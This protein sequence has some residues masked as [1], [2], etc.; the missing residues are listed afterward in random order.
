[1]VP[2]RTLVLGNEKSH[3]VTRHAPHYLFVAEF[4]ADLLDHPIFHA[5]PSLY[6]LVQYK[7]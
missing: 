2:I 7:A 4:A 1:M 5:P 6:C 3:H